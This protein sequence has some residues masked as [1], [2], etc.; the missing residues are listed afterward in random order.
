MA[1]KNYHLLA[2]SNSDYWIG[3][4][5]LFLCASRS[6]LKGFFIS[7][8]A[9][10]HKLLESQHLISTLPYDLNIE[11][12]HWQFPS[13]LKWNFNVDKIGS[14]LTAQHWS[15]LSMMKILCWGSNS[16]CESAFTPLWWG[17]HLHCGSLL[18]LACRKDTVINTLH[19]RGSV[20]KLD[21]LRLLDLFV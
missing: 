6:R 18:I 7:L 12:T 20:A 17:P 10:S 9:D 15:E 2:E 8:K 1:G 16:L 3:R 13:I 14:I 5:T 4:W 19:T 21:F 11:F